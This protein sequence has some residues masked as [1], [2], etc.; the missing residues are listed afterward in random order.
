MPLSE[1]D[2]GLFTRTKAT[3]DLVNLLILDHL[4]QNNKRSRVKDLVDSGSIVL[5]LNS[6]TLLIDLILRS[7]EAIANLAVQLHLKL[8]VHIIQ[9]DL[10][11]FLNHL[12]LLLLPHLVSLL[13]IEHLQCT[14]ICKVLLSLIVGIGVLCGREALG[15]L[16]VS[17]FIV[18]TAVI[19]TIVLLLI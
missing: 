7:L 6:D 2:I 10:L 3:E 1:V 9:V 11:V 18:L 16:L 19:A 4:V 14:T 15:L 8:M 5:V 13:P 17:D 12:L